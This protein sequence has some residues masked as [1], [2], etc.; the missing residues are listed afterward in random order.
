VSRPARYTSE[1]D[2]DL[3]RYE[4]SSGNNRIA[5]RGLQRLCEAYEAGKRLRESSIHRQLI[6]SHLT[7]DQV[8]LRRWSFKALGLIGNPEDVYRMVAQLKV[9]SDHETCS[10]GIAALIKTAGEADLGTICRKA[11]Q[12]LDKSLTLAARL[13]APASWIG[14][15]WKPVTVSLEDD[16]LALKW[17]I[18]LVG[19]GKAAV[20]MF[21]S[22]HGNGVFLGELNLHGNAEVCEYSA[23]GLWQRKD[24][25]AAHATVPLDAIAARPTNARKWLYRLYMR[26]PGEHGLDVD[27]FGALRK[28]EVTGAREGLALGVADLTTGVYDDAV[29]DWFEDEKDFAISETLL[30]GMARH[31]ARNPDFSCQVRATF[32]R[33]PPESAGRARL[34]AAAGGTTLFSELRALELLQASVAQGDL[35]Q[36]G[37]TIINQGELTMNSSVHAG[38]VNAQNVAGNDVSVGNNQANQQFAPDQGAQ[39]E[40]VGRILEF[41]RSGAL[42]PQPAAEVIERAQAAAAEPTPARRTALLDTLKGVAEGVTAAG[43]AGTALASLVTAASSLF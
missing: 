9:E 35:L 15:H 14:R 7:S 30:V 26:S 22:A 13:Y 5:K 6:H 17:A 31:G 8:L 40:L 28:A 42:P 27:A 16:D 20:D 41:A 21:H 1:A 4:L 25:G 34:L 36:R 3:L 43:S 29:L 32:K 11:G 12:S 23:W 2:A 38:T 24:L 33:M 10:W 37:T 39:A 19:Y 18:F